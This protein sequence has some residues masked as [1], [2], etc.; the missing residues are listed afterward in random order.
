MIKGNAGA[1]SPKLDQVRVWAVTGL[2]ELQDRAEEAGSLKA[3]VN[4]L[5]PTETRET[6]F[7]MEWDSG[8]SE[9]RLANTS[10]KRAE[11]CLR[12]GC[13]LVWSSDSLGVR[14]RPLDGLDGLKCWEDFLLGEISAAVLIEM[15]RHDM[16]PL[17]IEYDALGFDLRDLL[18]GLHKVG[19]NRYEKVIRLGQSLHQD[20]VE[21]ILSCYLAEGKP[22]PQLA[23]CDELWD[24][25]AWLYWWVN[26]SPN[27]LRLLELLDALHS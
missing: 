9:L 19:Y 11:S 10:D 18:L 12:L 2:Q 25:E 5:L 24:I 20:L 1:K 26:P 3:Y 14:M 6:A 23:D 15:L 22:E 16:L 4:G 27:L 8:S 7:W 13:R 17:D 21:A